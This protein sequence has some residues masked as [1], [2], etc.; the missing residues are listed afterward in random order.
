MDIPSGVGGLQHHFQIAQRH[1]WQEQ[2][3]HTDQHT[4]KAPEKSTTWPVYQK[5][6]QDTLDQYLPASEKKHSERHIV[7]EQNFLAKVGGVLPILHKRAIVDD[8]IHHCR[9]QG[10]KMMV[11]LL[12]NIPF[13]FKIHNRNSIL[14][15]ETNRSHVAKWWRFKIVLFLNS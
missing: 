7:G 8:T 13:M 3:H 9:S 4:D 14:G 5:N 12:K 15:N 6:L 2:G 11:T 10:L 1:T